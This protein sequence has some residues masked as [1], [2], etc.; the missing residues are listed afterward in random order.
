M[1]RL[2]FTKMHGAGNDYVFLDAFDPRTA[3]ELAGRDLGELARRVSDRNFGIGSDGLIVLTPTRVPGAACAMAMWNAD[4]S[5]GAMCGNGLRCLVKLACD[6]DR[7]AG[8][9]VVVATDAGLRRASVTRDANG[10]VA[11]VR[12]AMGQVRC[13]VEA[14]HFTAFGSTWALHDADAGNPHAVIFVAD[15]E[16]APVRELGAALQQ[17]PWFA[18]GVNVEFV[19]VRTDGCLVQRTFERGSGETL[20]CG[21]GACAV[22]TVAVATGRVP[23]PHV[24]IVLRGGSLRVVVGRDGAAMLDGPAETVF[25]GE[26]ADPWARPLRAELREPRA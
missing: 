26:L 14:R 17:H 20:A 16:Q 6:H 4:G 7:V 23:G 25:T 18:G 12:V 10:A 5:R 8:D 9:E 11:I 2:P 21:T 24:A 15:V 3:A 19:Q 1:S 13:S 22:A